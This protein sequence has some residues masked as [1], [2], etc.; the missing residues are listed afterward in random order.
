MR[1]IFAPLARAPSGPLHLTHLTKLFATPMCLSFEK[2]VKYH[3]FDK[4]VNFSDAPFV[5]RRLISF[6]VSKFFTASRH[7][8]RQDG[9]QN[10]RVPNETFFCSCQCFWQSQSLSVSELLIAF[11]LHSV[12]LVVAVS[13]QPFNFF[14]PETCALSVQILSNKRFVLVHLLYLVYG[15]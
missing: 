5:T 15:S 14:S 12:L 3:K 2:F 10:A 6:Q 8:S 7:H 9:S 1:S 13:F 11:N 4:M